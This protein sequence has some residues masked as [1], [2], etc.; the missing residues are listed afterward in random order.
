MIVSSWHIAALRDDQVEA[1]GALARHIWQR[2]YPGI[3]S[4]AQIDYMLHQRYARRSSAS[5]APTR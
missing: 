4:P 1:L 2:H 5:T 3:I